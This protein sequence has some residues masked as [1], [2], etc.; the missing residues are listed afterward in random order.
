M[1]IQ[2]QNKPCC[3]VPY[4]DYTNPTPFPGGIPTPGPAKI[5][6]PGPGVI[7]VAPYV[8][9][10]FTATAGPSP[11]PGVSPTPAPQGKE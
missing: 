3:Q 8:V 9:P 4:C 6:T 10:G 7:T 5:P 11:S 2:D 1:L